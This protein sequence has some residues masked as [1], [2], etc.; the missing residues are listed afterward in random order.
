LLLPIV[1]VAGCAALF[2]AASTKYEDS[3]FTDRYGRNP[4]V[5]AYWT[6]TIGYFAII[7]TEL[8]RLVIR[9]SGRCQRTALRLGLRLVVSESRSVSP[10]RC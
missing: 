10:I 6:I 8:A 5:M 3:N 4:L 7:L 1:A 9:H 2:F